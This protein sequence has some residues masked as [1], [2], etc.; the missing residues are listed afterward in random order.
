MTDVLTKE[1]RSRNMAAIK[2][3]DTSPEKIVRSLIHAMGFRYSLHRKDLPGKPD[4]VLVSRRKIIQVHGCFWHMHRCRFG[5]VK[6]ATNAEFWAAKRA[7]NA[8]RDRRN[9]RDLETRG[10]EVLIVWECWTKNSSALAKRLGT[11]LSK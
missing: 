2:C 8:Q 10:W 4:I 7:S 3:K 6:P 9:R 11:F 5:R 1:Q